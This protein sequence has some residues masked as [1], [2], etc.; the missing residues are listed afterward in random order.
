METGLGSAH[1]AGILALSRPRVLGRRLLSGG[2]A[3]PVAGLGDSLEM[4]EGSS[5]LLGP[6]P[7]CL[8]LRVPGIYEDEHG[9]TWV[10][11]VRRVS[12]SNQFIKRINWVPKV[13]GE[14][15]MNRLIVSLWKIPIRLQ[16]PQ[17]M[18]NPVV[19]TLPRMW[20]LH[21]ERRYL[22]TDSRFWE[23]LDYYQMGFREQLTMGLMTE[24][25]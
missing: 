19:A 24:D 18:V 12:F 20:H 10:A 5:P 2:E 13:P 6:Y 25:Q 14:R 16:A 21:P 3:D 7:R 8:W 1:L 9:R 17:G 22:A 4:S 11:F 23:I 15:P